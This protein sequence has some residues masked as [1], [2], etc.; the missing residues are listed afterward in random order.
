MSV[1]LFVCLFVCLSVRHKQFSTLT[2]HLNLTLP[3]YPILPLLPY[4]LYLYLYYIT[5][6]LTFNFCLPCLTQPYHRLTPTLP[7]PLFTL[8]F[9]LFT[10][11]LSL[12]LLPYT[13]F[14]ITLKPL[15][16]LTS[17]FQHRST[18]TQQIVW[19]PFQPYF[20]YPTLPYQYHPKLPYP[21][22][23]IIIPHNILYTFILYT[24]T[25]SFWY[26]PYLTQ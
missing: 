4:N 13:L 3:Y 5:I 1:C 9:P 17:N 11:T 19:D 12:P 24:S 15:D 22:L 6:F 10:L 26:M 20:C 18:L 16:R 7:F 14:C 23:P 2:N 21:N 8:P 25:Y